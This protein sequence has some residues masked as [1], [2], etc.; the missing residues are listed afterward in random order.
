MNAVAASIIGVLGTG[1]LGLLYMQFQGLHKA[2]EKGFATI[3]SRFDRLEDRFDRLEDRFDRLETRV[4]SL[5]TKFE[6]LL[7][8]VGSLEGRFDRL[9]NRFDRFDIK[10]T[11]HLSVH[12]ERL[13]R[14]EVELN[15]DPPPAEAA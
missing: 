10:F 3:G 7:A 11:G 2:M 6:S 13:A 9:E 8:K 14:I 4:G 1:F 12:G 15:I 5:E